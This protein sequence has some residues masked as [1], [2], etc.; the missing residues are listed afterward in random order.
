MKKLHYSFLLSII[1]AEQA[2]ANPIIEPFDLPPAQIVG[3][4]LEESPA[5]RAAKS[6][7]TLAQARKRGLDSGPYEFSLDTAGQRRKIKDANE[8]HNEWNVALER[9]LRVPGKGGIDSGIGD[10]GVQIAHFSYSDAFHEGA[11]GL[12]TQ[13][14]DWV[15][16][17][18][19]A[20]QWQAQVETLQK[21]SDVVKKREKSGDAAMLEASMA[22]AAVA[23]A[24]AS[25]M[26]AQARLQIAANNLIQTYP[27]LQLPE[28]IVLSDPEFIDG[29][30]EIWRDRILD[31][32]H[33]VGRVKAET[34]QAKSQAARAQ[35]DLIPDPTV[36]VL[37]GS[38]Q[39][40]NENY[41]GVKL[42]IPLPG[43]TPR[44]AEAAAARAQASIAASNEVLA[45]RNVQNT[46]AAVYA[47]AT[48]SYRSW[49]SAKVAMESVDQNAA[50]MARAYELGEVGL[51]DLLIS[52]RLQAES[53]L[54]YTLAHIDAL[55]SRYRLL[56]DAHQLW[57]SPGEEAE[58]STAP[59]Q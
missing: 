31:G 6:G 46:I 7:I 48:S 43:G 47:K 28:N 37:Y 30:L 54:T 2:Y 24:E 22:Q 5:V 8:S 4:I 49:Q 40:G 55:E 18:S 11:R 56:V 14:F 10:A 59:Q 21:Q 9:P 33:E 58:K 38:E 3:K 17:K 16:A 25:L 27:S 51:T 23:Q 50:K 20:S 52:R 42:S 53:S 13:W 1:W 19:E 12:L 44:S 57:T 45:I 32:N 29:T 39:G 35:L 15:K 41:L 34:M 36:G 26:Q